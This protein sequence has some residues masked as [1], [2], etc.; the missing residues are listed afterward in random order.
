MKN[1]SKERWAFT[2]IELSV[3]IAI[4]AILAAMALPA[5]A[6]PKPRAQRAS[7]A[8]NL[9]QLGI[10]FQTWAMNQND[11]YPMIVP[12]ASGGPPNQTQI[13]AGGAAYV[14]Q[15]LAVMSNEVS[16]AR[17]LACPAD[18][19]TVVHTNLLIEANAT[20]NEPVPG[21]GSPAKYSLCDFNVS[22]FV[23]LNADENYPSMLLCG[24]RNIDGSQANPTYNST[25]NNGYGNA[26][27]FSPAMIVEGTNF[28]ATATAPA[29]TEKMHQEAGNVLLCDGSVQQLTSPRLRTQLRNSGDLTTTPGPNTLLFP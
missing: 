27:H 4:I 28:V 10:A 16:S 12:T 9:K 17:V 3:V 1:Q 7:C 15:I 20:M 14:Y 29:W 19:D 5:L 13:A 2:L 18:S 8:N 6:R 25:I 21:S 26:Q 11:A 24:D 23:G 22:Y